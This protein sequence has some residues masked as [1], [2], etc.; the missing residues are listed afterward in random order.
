MSGHYVRALAIASIASLAACS[1]GSMNQSVPSTGNSFT[2]LSPMAY[3][4]TDPNTRAACD[5]MPLPGQA[6]CYALIHTDIP[7][8]LGVQ[9]N[10][11]GYGPPDYDSAYHLPTGALAGKGQKIAIVD[12]YDDPNAESDL[13]VYRSQYGL[14]TCTT[15]NGCFKKVNQEGQQGNYPQANAGWAGEE[16]LDVDMVSAVCPHCKIILVEA[17]SNYFNDLGASVNEA[18]KLK[19]NV[20]SNSYGGGEGYTSNPDYDHPGHIITASSGDGGYGAQQPC[21]L[22]T[23]VCVGGTTLAKGGSGTRGWTEAGWRDAGSGCSALVTKPTWQT[24]TG[25]T[26]RSEAD[27]SAVAVGAAVYDTYQNRGWIVLD[28]TSV[29]SPLI[30]AVFGLAKNAKAQNYAQNIWVNG[31]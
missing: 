22:S 11:S 16:S 25:C 19:A 29:S 23:V 31:G 26:M 6:R 12:A 4:N 9:P 15:A 7:G 27:T 18:I 13:Q 8:K 1:G 24:D 3:H 30:A 17:N 10:V 21:S 28:G 20:V 5:Y 2:N 14:P